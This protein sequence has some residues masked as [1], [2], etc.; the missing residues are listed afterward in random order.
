MRISDW[1]SDVCSSDLSCAAIGRGYPAHGGSQAHTR[2]G[3]DFWRSERVAGR[4][5]RGQLCE[6]AGGSTGG[7]PRRDHLCEKPSRGE[8]RTTGWLSETYSERRTDG[9]AGFCG[10]SAKPHSTDETCFNGNNSL[11]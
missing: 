4:S 11:E 8:F 7:A 9:D 3:S 2:G 10:H 1:S 6:H 5:R